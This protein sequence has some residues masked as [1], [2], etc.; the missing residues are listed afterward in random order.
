MHITWLHYVCIHL[1]SM[2]SLTTFSGPSVYPANL[3]VRR[4]MSNSLTFAWDKLDNDQ[5]GLPITGYQY[6]LY[7][8]QLPNLKGRISKFATSHT[9]LF[10]ERPYAI[11][12]AAINEG[13]V[14]EASP[15]VSVYHEPAHVSGKQKGNV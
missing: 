5:L 3:R 8:Q 9:V 7:T 6:K 2:V 4:V 10:S 15:L 13:G 12:L 11:S 14:G 1:L